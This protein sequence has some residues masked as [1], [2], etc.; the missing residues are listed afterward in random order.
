VAELD[1]LVAEAPFPF[2]T[3]WKRGSM[4]TTPATER[5]G[6]AFIACVMRPP[7]RPPAMRLHVR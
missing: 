3:D 2:G 5:G 1:R 7:I 6:G 4:T